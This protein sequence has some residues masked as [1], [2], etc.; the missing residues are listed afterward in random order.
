MAIV[1]GVDVGTSGLKALAIEA[2]SGAALASAHR[3][4]PLSTPRPGWA[5]Q[6]PEDFARAAVE[7]LREIA[8]ALGARA[9]SVRAIGVTEVSFAT[10]CSMARSSTP[11]RRPRS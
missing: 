3:D 9:R 4:Y 10:S 8:L 1:I 6:E 2:E 11:S 5:E 7:A